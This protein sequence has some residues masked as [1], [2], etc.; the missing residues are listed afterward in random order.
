MSTPTSRYTEES[1]INE[2]QYFD[3]YY[4]VCVKLN[5]TD[6]YRKWLAELEKLKI[7]LNISKIFDNLD[8]FY[9]YLQSINDEKVFVILL[10]G[11]TSEDWDWHNFRLP[12]S[13]PVD[14]NK[15]IF[16]TPQFVRIYILGN[17]KLTLNTALCAFRSKKNLLKREQTL[18]MINSQWKLWNEVSDTTTTDEPDIICYEKNALDRFYDEFHQFNRLFF[19]KYSVFD[20]INSVLKHIDS[21]TS[22]NIILIIIDPSL[23]NVLRIINN[24]K[25]VFLRITLKS[26]YFYENDDVH[27]PYLYQMTYFIDSNHLVNVLN[28]DTAPNS[29]YLNPKELVFSNNENQM[30]LR[31]SEKVHFELLTEHL[32]CLFQTESSKKEMIEECR[33]QYQTDPIEQKKIDEFE[34][35]YC[36]PQA[37]SWYTK[38]SFLCR[39]LNK[40]CRTEDIDLI[41]T[42]RFYIHDLYQQLHQL[43]ADFIQYLQ[44]IDVDILH[45]YRGQCM[46]SSEFKDLQQN[47]GKLYS[48]T[49]FLSTTLDPDVAHEYASFSYN[50]IQSDF[51]NVLFEYVVDLNLKQTKPFAEISKESFMKHEHEVLFCM[52][53]VFRIDRI[54]KST[55]NSTWNVK[56]TLVEIN[57]Q[58]QLEQTS[59]QV[60]LKLGDY[61]VRINEFDKAER[62][63]RLMLEDDQENIDNMIQ[64][65]ERIAH[66]YTVKGEYAAVIEM[67]QTLIKLSSS[68]PYKTLE[69]Y[70]EIAQIYYH[71][72]EYDQALLHYELVLNLNV[73]INCIDCAILYTS[74]AEIH[75]IKMNWSAAQ[76]NYMK[77]LAV[78]RCPEEL[79]VKCMKNLQFVQEK[80]KYFSRWLFNH[81]RWVLWIIA[82]T[83]VLNIIY[84]FY[85]KFSSIQ[86][87]ANCKFSYED[88]QCFFSIEG[89]FLTLSFSY[90]CRFLFEKRH[91]F[92]IYK[93]QVK[94]T[95]QLVS[96]G[97][98]MYA[99][100]QLGPYICSIITTP[101]DLVKMR[102]I[103]SL[104]SMMIEFDTAH[105]LVMVY[106]YLPSYFVFI[107][108]A[109]KWLCRAV[110]YSE[111]G[112]GIL[113]I[114]D[115]VREVGRIELFRTYIMRNKSHNKR[116]NKTLDYLY[117]NLNVHESQYLNRLLNHF[118]RR[119][120]IIDRKKLRRLLLATGTLDQLY[121][122]SYI[123]N[124]L[125]KLD[126]LILLKL[127]LCHQMY[128]PV[129]YDLLLALCYLASVEVFTIY[130]VLV[131]PIQAW[132][133]D[134][135][136]TI[137]E[138]HDNNERNENISEVIQNKVE[139]KHR[140]DNVE[141]AKFFLLIDNTNH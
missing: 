55:D 63:Y 26:I 44:D 88:R 91:G 74:I 51:Q 132:F 129:R 98:Q 36:I 64:V 99:F 87:Y 137:L 58:I 125:L 138:Q 4:I 76:Q 127:L 79:R 117:P 27:L 101:I 19:H 107:I 109:R 115:V 135:L 77:A 28:R 34:E 13:L 93:K 60:L 9:N 82:Y 69:I 86:W 121:V 96:T 3:D 118:V 104:T 21:C 128:F 126:F 72:C 65:Y 124:G 45:L 1:L 31:S 23:Y 114:Y 90:I 32:S 22:Q 80:N 16:Y 105:Y 119:F 110:R 15:F 78:Q 136:L 53:S 52:G 70:T 20:E 59:T 40:A 35:S 50:D 134:P 37:I 43:H 84:L 42:F 7:R 123:P 10:T 11:D 111:L 25:C 18:Y 73:D 48:T 97:I 95:L 85:S 141:S 2:K 14:I 49:T 29:N 24:D 8:T 81:I 113:P 140:N 120:S 46:S 94:T 62:Y 75:R 12:H 122:L 39:L 92:N 6:F 5:A 33:K 116:V 38:D 17:Q 103:L 54:E 130:G 47:I 131:I 56:A 41:Y 61:A 89:M 106:L 102:V 66:L 57:E 108:I 71:I 83:P 30:S 139:E 68:L 133:F 112:S 100:W 67:C